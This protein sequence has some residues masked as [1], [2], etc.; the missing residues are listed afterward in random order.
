LIGCSLGRRSDRRKLRVLLL[1]SSVGTQ[2]RTSSQ[3]LIG[4]SST[5]DPQRAVTR[6]RATKRSRHSLIDI[7]GREGS[8]QPRCAPHLEEIFDYIAADNSRAV[9]ALVARIEKAAAFIGHIPE[10]GVKTSR[11]QFR[12]YS[13][14]N[15]LIVYEITPD[16]VSS[17]M[18]ATVH[19]SARGRV[20]RLP[21]ECRIDWK[22]DRC[23]ITAALSHHRL[24]A[25]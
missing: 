2:V 5:S 12:K 15:Y 19:A 14:G 4:K 8:F 16:E 10:I 17:S 3:N 13:V 21:G 20:N 18:S 9:A 24:G 23:A 22:G 25:C 7:G 6:S 11:P 1:R